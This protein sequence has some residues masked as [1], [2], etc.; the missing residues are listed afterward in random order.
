MIVLTTMDSTSW[1]VTRPYHTQEP[2]GV[3]ICKDI[4]FSNWSPHGA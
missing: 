1:G 3:Y 2:C 4:I